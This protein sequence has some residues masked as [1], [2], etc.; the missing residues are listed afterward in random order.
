VTFAGIAPTTPADAEL[1]VVCRH[2]GGYANARIA[3]RVRQAEGFFVDE[4]VVDVPFE[5]RVYPRA[6]RLRSLVA[7]LDTRPSAGNLVT[8]KSGAGI[9]FADLRP[10]QVGDELRHVNWRASAR[11]GSVWVNSRHPEQNADVILFLDTFA[12]VRDGR[13]GTLDLTVRAAAAAARRYLLDH[14]RVGVVGFGGTLR[15]LEPDTGDRQLYR[16]VETLITTSLA[17]SYAW[18]DVSTIPAPMMPPHALIL[19][20]TPLVDPRGIG[21][22]YDL[23]RRR[24]DVSIIAVSPERFLPPAGDRPTALALRLWRLERDELIGQLR[25]TG[26]AVSAWDGDRSLDVVLEEVIRFRRRAIE[27][28]H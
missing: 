5:V 16:I 3:M 27:H 6:D 7:P 9:E 4:R 15:W 1:Q 18:K 14:A 24:L 21:A 12:D 2:W 17:F 19:A 13:S 10:F 22:V 20:I 11:R 23:L 25:E 8:R 28:A 26:G